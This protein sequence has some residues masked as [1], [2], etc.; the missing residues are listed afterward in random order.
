MYGLDLPFQFFVTNTCVIASRLGLYLCHGVD[1]PVCPLSLVLSAQHPT[2][3]S[4]RTQCPL[5]RGLVPAA[6]H[7]EPAYR[8]EPAHKAFGVPTDKVLEVGLIYT[9]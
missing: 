9:I 5:K 1:H 3:G 2:K 6:L 7:S 4:F 8:G